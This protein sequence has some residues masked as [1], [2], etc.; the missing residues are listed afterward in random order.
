M[1][2]TPIYDEIH[3]FMEGVKAQTPA[4]E[5]ALQKMGKAFEGWQVHIDHWGQQFGK[6]QYMIGVEATNQAWFAAERKNRE[7]KERL[8][9]ERENCLRG[10][11]LWPIHY[12]GVY[13]TCPQCNRTDAFINETGFYC[14]GFQ[15]GWGRPRKYPVPEPKP[16]SFGPFAI[17]QASR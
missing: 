16:I 13:F 12:R 11:V 3:K 6:N 15:C 5:D 17:L 10:R 8:K 4:I 14:V 9:K 7:R 2:G 1:A